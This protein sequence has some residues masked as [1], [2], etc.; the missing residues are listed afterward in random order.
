LCLHRSQSSEEDEMGEIAIA[1]KQHVISEIQGT[2]G[3]RKE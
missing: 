1:I 3:G 2:E